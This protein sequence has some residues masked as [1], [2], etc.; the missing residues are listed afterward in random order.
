LKNSKGFG[1]ANTKHRLNLLFGE[2]AS[3]FLTNENENKVLAKLKI[4]IG[5]SD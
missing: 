5:G 1:V 2:R 4:P 3:F